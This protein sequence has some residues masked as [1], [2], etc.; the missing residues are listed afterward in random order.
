MSDEGLSHTQTWDLIPWVVNGTATAGQRARVE[1]HLRDCADCRREFALQQ[2]FQAGLREDVEA[3]PDPRPGLERLFARIDADTVPPAAAITHRGGG[4]LPW[5]AAAV[6]VQSVGLALLAGLLLGRGAAP[7]D[8]RTFSAA[9][10]RSE[11]VIRLVVAPDTTLAALGELLAD[12]R[13]HIVESTADNGAFGLA[14]RDATTS[15][16]VAATVAELRRRPGVLLA[17]PIAGAAGKA[18]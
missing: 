10:A 18:P 16:D 13:L 12:T 4:W 6:V 5:L 14:P 11:A 17:E 3:D 1:L 8:Y 2:Q 7:D 15:P 9:P